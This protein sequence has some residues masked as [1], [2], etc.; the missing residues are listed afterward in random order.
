MY[1]EHKFSFD[2]LQGL[3]KFS[4]PVGSGKTTLAEAI[5]YGLYGTVKGQGNL[6]LISWN[7]KD[8]EVEMTI[9]SRNKKIEIF[10]S[11]HK[12]LIVKIDGKVL[13]A[14]NK[15]GT[16]E[17]LEQDIYD[18]PKLAVMK[19][20]VITFDQFNSLAKMNPYDTKQFL[21]EIF[22][23][24]LFTDFNNEIVIERKQEMNEQIKIESILDET[25]SQIENLTAKKNEQQQEILDTID[26]SGLEE[27]RVSLVNIG[28][29]KKANLQKMEDEHLEE[30]QVVRKE[31][32]ECERKMTELMTLG[33]QAKQEYNTFKDGECPTCHHKIEQSLIDEH[34]KKMKGYADEYRVWEAK[35]K[36]I[37]EKLSNLKM[38]HKTDESKISDEIERVRKRIHEID[39]DIKSHQ[40][41]LELVSENYDNLIND[42]MKHAEMLKEKLENHSHEIGE[43][44]EMSDL[45]TKTLRYN[46]LETLIPHINKSIQF[47]VNKLEQPYHVKFDQEFKAHIY[48]DGWE[49]EISYS[50]LSTGQKKTLD[51][52]VIFGIMQNIIANVDFNVF[53][54]D[55]LMSNTDTDLRNTMLSLLNDTFVGDKDNGEAKKSIFVVNHAEMQDDFFAHKIRVR[56]ENKKLITNKGRKNEQEHI[57]RASKYD[58]VF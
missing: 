35:K 19:M 10:R 34:Y 13:P 47:F 26:K 12:P 6:G 30:Q 43:W 46:L 9:T 24:K 18:V 22:G 58:I 8:C 57:V 42:A 17:I 5:I 50:N 23:F 44:N 28:K 4:G 1:G 33:K 38:K 56:L 36:E 51:S 49:K 54:L 40:H 15:R 20:C 25:L 14:S 41:G 3:I 16:Q 31:I 11:I 2:K 21:D 53:V 48:V 45:F 27:E 52:A 39:S 55:E 7:E 32:K 29:E 37:D